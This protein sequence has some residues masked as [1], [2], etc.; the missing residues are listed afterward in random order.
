MVKMAY[1]GTWKVLVPWKDLINMKNMVRIWGSLICL[2]DRSFKLLL[3]LSFVLKFLVS[4]Y[5]PYERQKDLRVPNWIF[6]DFFSYVFNSFP[7]T[8]RPCKWI[9]NREN[10]CYIICCMEQP[11][12]IQHECSTYMVYCILHIKETSLSC[13]YLM[14]SVNMSLYH[15]SEA[16][17]FIKDTEHCIQYPSL[18]IIIS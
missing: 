9:S 6:M 16:Q 14:A 4:D 5:M 7:C 2:S 17:G 8:G 11:T 10:A 12:C 1:S 13:T 18:I 3:F 15:E